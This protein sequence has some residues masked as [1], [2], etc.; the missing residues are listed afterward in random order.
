MERFNREPPMCSGDCVSAFIAKL[1]A[2]VTTQFEE[3]AP[4]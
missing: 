2:S 4:R 3:V 1:L